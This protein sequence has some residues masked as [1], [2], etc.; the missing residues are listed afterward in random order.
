MSILSPCLLRIDHRELRHRDEISVYLGYLTVRVIYF[1]IVN[2]I[3][4]E[5]ALLPYSGTIY[6]FTDDYET[7]NSIKTLC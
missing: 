5:V 2:E 7:L 1:D 4:R 3:V 6:S